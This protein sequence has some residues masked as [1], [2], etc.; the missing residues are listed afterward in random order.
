MW[1]IYKMDKINFNELTDREKAIVNLAVDMAAEYTMRLIPE[2]IGNV[3]LSKESDRRLMIKFYKDNPDLEN[4]R[5][6]VAAEVVAYKENH[7]TL[8]LAEI[9]KEVTPII[10]QKMGMAGKLNMNTITK[11]SDLSFKG[12][13]GDHGQ[14]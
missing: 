4:H 3:I 7:S 6:I 8:T 5:D 10:R 1:R 12:F 13:N 14:I 11:P 2:F 9:I